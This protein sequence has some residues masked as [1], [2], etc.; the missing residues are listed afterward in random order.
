MEKK[1]QQSY[2][3]LDLTLSEELTNKQKVKILKA[4]KILED[5]LEGCSKVRKEEDTEVDM[6][7]GRPYDHPRKKKI[8]VDVEECDMADVVMND[9][10]DDGMIDN[11][12]FAE[13]NDDLDED[14]FDSDEPNDISHVPNQNSIALYASLIKQMSEYND[15]NE[16][17]KAAY[18]AFFNK[19]LKQYGATSPSQLDDEKKKEFFDKID[20]GWKAKKETD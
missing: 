19:T 2:N 12:V 7:T 5:V 1:L 11:E 20:K 18:K 14:D 4:E 8:S 10:N 13:P 3:L 15:L 16:D 9:S 6:S 17:D